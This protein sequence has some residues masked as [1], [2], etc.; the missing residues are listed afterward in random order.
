MFSDYLNTGYLG[1]VVVKVTGYEFDNGQKWN[2]PEEK[3]EEYAVRSNDS[4]HIGEPTPTPVPTF[5]PDATPAPE[6]EANP[7][8]G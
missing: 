5:G 7:G 6:S 4:S 3:Q 1:Y 2:I 8:N